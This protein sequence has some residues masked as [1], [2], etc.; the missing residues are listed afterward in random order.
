MNL[1]T[2]DILSAAAVRARASATCAENF[3]S[4]CGAKTFRY[5]A[6]DRG[7]VCAAPVKDVVIHWRHQPDGR[8]RQNPGRRAHAGGLKQTP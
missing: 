1:A 8:F 3:P 2:A 6:A 5:L 7:W 4:L